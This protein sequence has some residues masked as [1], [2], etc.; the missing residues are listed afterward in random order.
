MPD[1]RS[2]IR[3]I[4]RAPD[5][6]HLVH[7]SA[8]A[9]P[10]TNAG[11]VAGSAGRT[12]SEERIPIVEDKL[13]VGKREVAW[14]RA[15]ALLCRRAAACGAWTA[16]MRAEDAFQ[17]RNIEVTESASAATA[18]TGGRTSAT[19]IATRPGAVKSL[20]GSDGSQ[21]LVPDRVSK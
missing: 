8:A 21:A 3:L 19:R 15:R 9:T 1:T 17:E 10:G 13:R 5:R 2:S 20:T 16:G 12:V 14:R 4:T 18:R 11:A 7:G 6:R